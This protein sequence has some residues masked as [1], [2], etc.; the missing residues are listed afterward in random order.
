MQ[1]DTF[2]PD[3]DSS[4]EEYASDSSGDLPK[5][6]NIGV[7]YDPISTDGRFLDQSSHVHYEKL[8]RKLFNPQLKKGRIVYFTHHT[9]NSTFKNTI[10]LVEAYK[11]NG[12]DNV[13][14]FEF[15]GADIVN[16][17]STNS[18]FVDLHIPEI[19]HKACKQNE[20]GVPIIFRIKTGSQSGS[21][22][23]NYTLNEQVGSYC[24]YFT[25][26][27]LSSLTLKLLD[28]TGTLI[29]TNHPR[30]ILEFEITVLNDTLSKR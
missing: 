17:V 26:I 11:L 15:I 10:D 25:P 6:N 7:K 18:P 1:S 8:N 4:D 2:L 24:N 13:I 12:L 21:E 3:T 16:T 28:K 14:G 29:T 19:P 22:T 30:I 9:D 20:Y 23:D 5:T 27:K